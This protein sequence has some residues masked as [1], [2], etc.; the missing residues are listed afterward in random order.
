MRIDPRSPILA[1][2]DWGGLLETLSRSPDGAALA[3]ASRSVAMGVL[4]APAAVARWI[5]ERAPGLM[6]RSPLRL[7]IVGAERLDAVDR[8]R[9]YHL[10]PAL[11]GVEGRVDVTL[12]GERLHTDFD[13]PLRAVA[14]GEAAQSFV[15]T[16][17][18]FLQVTDAPAPDLAFVFH[19]GFQ[20][21]RGWLRDRSLSR[22]I[23]AGVPVVAVSYGVD[24]YEMDRWV[25]ECHGF[26]VAETLLLNPFYVD[27]GEANVPV[28]WGRA[29]WCFAPV[30]TLAELSVDNER[31]AALDRL[32]DMV[33]HSMT[34]ERVP[35]APYG[36]MIE[37][38]GGNGA[39]RRCI[40]LFDDFVCD[41]VDG[42]IMA[43]SSGGLARVAQLSA[44]DLVRYPGAGGSGLE[45]AVWAADV[46]HRHLMPLYPPARAGNSVQGLARTMYANLEN[47]LDELF[48]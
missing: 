30:A 25:V 34:L 33:L 35:R 28:R 2:G 20:K 43:L 24:E 1:A 21:N 22:L 45:R 36:A 42:A 5:A 7:L 8:G 12:V 11:L 47:R 15:G 27:L 38:R 29:L 3:E 41:P 31:L 17:G 48:R 16:L 46:K 26:S 14:P 19:P 6:E 39:G 32:G 44:E 37:L 18:A 23:A 4:A 40:Y 10:I 13:S 9:W